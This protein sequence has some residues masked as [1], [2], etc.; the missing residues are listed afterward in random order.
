MESLTEE[1]KEDYLQSV[2]KAIVDFV[3]RD[4]REKDCEDVNLLPEPIRELKL[5]TPKPWHKAFLAARHSLA[6]SLH[7]I[8]PCMLQ[9]RFELVTCTHYV[10]KSAWVFSFLIVICNVSSQLLELWDTNYK[11]LRMVDTRQFQNMK[12][13][14]ELSRF[15]HICMNHIEAAKEKLLKQ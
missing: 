6:K 14:M 4:P 8:N 15:Q 13:P 3:L 2:K 9:V 1:T 5:M 7:A 12:D 10:K 11:D